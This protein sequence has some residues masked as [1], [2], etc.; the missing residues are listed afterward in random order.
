LQIKRLQ[1]F[2]ACS[3]YLYIGIE[4]KRRN[5]KP[6]FLSPVTLKKHFRIN[7]DKIYFSIYQMKNKNL[8]VPAVLLSMMSVQGGASIAK[9]LFPILG[10]AGTSSLRIGLAGII[11]SIINRPKIKNFTRQ[12]WLYCLGYGFCIAFMNLLFYYGIQRIPLGLGVTVEF[13]GP[14]TLAL[15]TSRRISDIIWA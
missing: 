14:F 9:F 15:I 11:L 13:I 6:V 5:I 8:A 10:A 2:T 1:A 12:E 7:P 4:E 3:L